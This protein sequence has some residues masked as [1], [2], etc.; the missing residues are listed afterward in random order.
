MARNYMGLENIEE[1]HA[2]L[3]LAQSRI[4]DDKPLHIFTINF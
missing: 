3:S 4:H 2:L 1:P